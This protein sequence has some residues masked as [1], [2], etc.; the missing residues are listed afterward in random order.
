MLLLR[1]ETFDFILK[2]IIFFAHMYAFEL[3]SYT[4]LC[5]N[6]YILISYIKYKFYYVFKA[7]LFVQ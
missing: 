1:I 6:V 2:I 3:W 7:F 4:Y 5:V